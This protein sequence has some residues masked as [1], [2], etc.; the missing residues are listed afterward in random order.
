MRTRVFHDGV[1]PAAAG[2]LHVTNKYA[3]ELNE[4]VAFAILSASLYNDGGCAVENK[5]F[6]GVCRHHL[7]RTG[8]R[9][10]QV[11]SPR[12]VAANV[13]LAADRESIGS[14]HVPMAMTV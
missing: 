8:H 4:R 3:I 11:A 9:R 13:R 7:Q 1:T 6:S 5:E 2:R 12:Q 10:R 14:H